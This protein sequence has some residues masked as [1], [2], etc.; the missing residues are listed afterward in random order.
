MPRLAVPPG[1][2][3]GGVAEW[4]VMPAHRRHH[5]SANECL[6]SS[7][8]NMRYGSNSSI[9]GK[10]RID[11]SL[12]VGSAV[13]LLSLAPEPIFPHMAKGRF[14]AYCSAVLSLL[15]GQFGVERR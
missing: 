3:R 6:L 12:R 1:A 9:P 5:S 13:E 8:T 15:T 4:R 10:C 14:P 7:I 2:C 11:D